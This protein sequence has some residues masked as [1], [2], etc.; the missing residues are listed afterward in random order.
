MITHIK[1]I[2]R[3]EDLGEDMPEKLI[4]IHRDPKRSF[5]LIGHP[6]EYNSKEGLILDETLPISFVIDIFASKYYEG[7]SEMYSKAISEENLE[8]WDYNPN[9][10]PTCSVVEL[11]E[12]WDER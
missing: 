10:Y 1:P 2:E 12:L 4:L 9:E 3:L 7:I 8:T 11:F 6:R 5:T